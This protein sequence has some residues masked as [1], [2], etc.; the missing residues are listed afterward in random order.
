MNEVSPTFIGAVVSALAVILG[1]AVTWKKFS[2]KSEPREITP[3]PLAV[4]QAPE[5]AE[6]KELDALRVELIQRIVDHERRNET[7]MG[8]IRSELTILRHGSDNVQRRINNMASTLYSIAGKLGIVS[9]AR[10][11]EG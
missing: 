5:Y 9:A 1:L 6:K 7:D 8:L 3:Q 11:S 2:G 10:D 4:K